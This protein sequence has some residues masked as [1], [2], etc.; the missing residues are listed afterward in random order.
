MVF[1]RKCLLPVYSIAINKSERYWSSDAVTQR[2]ELSFMLF[3]FFSLCQTN[4]HRWVEIDWKALNWTEKEREKKRRRAQVAIPAAALDERKLSS[5]MQ[6][7]NGMCLI[8]RYYEIQ[9]IQA[10]SLWNWCGWFVWIRRHAAFFADN[11]QW[12]SLFFCYPRCIDFFIRLTYAHQSPI[13]FRTNKFWM[14]Q[15]ENEQTIQM[16]H[17]H[18]E[19]KKPAAAMKPRKRKKWTIAHVFVNWNSEKRQPL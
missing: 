4:S 12:T 18:T 10:M 1:V 16:H 19:E 6:K 11:L 9:C 17:E 5:K 15:T 2:F 7:S 8:C 13:P 14:S 3:F